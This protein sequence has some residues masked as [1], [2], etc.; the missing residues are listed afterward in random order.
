[1]FS[2]TSISKDICWMMYTEVEMESISLFHYQEAATAHG[3]HQQI[4]FWYGKHDI[5]RTCEWRERFIP[6]VTVR[7]EYILDELTH[8]YLLHII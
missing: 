1:M 5:N 6:W 7:K 4:R 8:S 3:E 2:K